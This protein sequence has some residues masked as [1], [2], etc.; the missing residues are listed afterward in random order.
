MTKPSGFGD[1]LKRYFQESGLNF[2]SPSY[3]WLVV[4]GARGQHKGSGTIN[5]RAD[6]GFMLTII[7]GQLNGDGVDKFHIKFGT[8][9]PERS[10][11]TT[12]CAHPTT[13]RRQPS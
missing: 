5:G 2:H 7:D 12:G 11:M 13:S 4:S 10:Y 9:S 8:S 6:Y 1:L 3:D